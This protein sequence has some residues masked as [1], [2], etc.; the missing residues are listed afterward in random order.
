MALNWYLRMNKGYLFGQ[1]NNGTSAVHRLDPRTKIYMLIAYIII[2]I[3]AMRWIPVAIIGVFAFIFVLLSDIPFGNVFKA[4]FWI[5]LFFFCISMLTII[6]LGWQVAVMLLI[7]LFGITIVTEIVIMSTRPDDLLSGF[8]QGFRMPEEMSMM[9]MLNFSFLPVFGSEMR[10]LRDTMAARG[11]DNVEGKLFER[12]M[13]NTPLVSSVLRRS[14]RKNASI[15]DAMRLKCYDKDSNRIVMK[16][17]KFTT[18]DRN[19]L[20]IM[21]VVIAAVVVMQFVVKL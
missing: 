18:L 14:K 20:I 8:S 7:R 9:W 17:L 21:I 11:H 4:A 10:V 2:S 5:Y 1:F 15:S 13:F 19:A 3:L 16:P 6:F 12:I